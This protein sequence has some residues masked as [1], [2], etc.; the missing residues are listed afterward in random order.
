MKIRIVGRLP[1]VSAQLTHRGR[2]AFFENVLLDTGSGSSIFSA[3]VLEGAGIRPPGNA[4]IRQIAG[5]GGSESVLEMTVDS[6]ALGELTVQNF[7]IE[8]GAVDYGFDFDAILGFD[9]LSQTGA[10]I[11]LDKMELRR[12]DG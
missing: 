4:P 9:F 3:A 6:V 7:I 12:S 8:S 1:M 2:A 10:V 11:D 5:V